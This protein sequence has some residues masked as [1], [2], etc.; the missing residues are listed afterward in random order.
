MSFYS[1][2]NNK[3]FFFLS[4]INITKT[5]DK[6]LKP[7]MLVGNRLI[8]VYGT[9][10][11][12][13]EFRKH[14]F[15][16]VKLCEMERTGGK[17]FSF[18]LA[19][20]PMEVLVY[21]FSFVT[22]ARDKVKLRYVSQRLRTAA[23]APSLWRDFTWSHYDSRE[24]ISIKNVLK[25]CGRYVQR[26][27]FPH[28]V[29]PVVYFQCCCNVK[30]LSL[31]CAKLTLEHLR[32]IMQ[33]MRKLQYLD[34]LW[35]SQN[36]IKWYFWVLNYPAYGQTIKELTIRERLD[37]SSGFYYDEVFL[38]L[39]KQWTKLKLIP[40]TLNICVK[41]INKSSILSALCQWTLSGVG[42]NFLTAHDNGN[43]NVYNKFNA[44]ISIPAFSSFQLKF[45]GT[46]ILFPFVTA[47][48]HGLGLPD[49]IM[50]NSQ[51]T[52]NGGVLHQGVMAMCYRSI[53][54]SKP[55]NPA[56]I[57]FITHFDVSEYGLLDSSHLEQLAF[58]CPKLQ[59]LNLFGNNNCLK[60]LQGLRVIASC[61][62]KL[63]G[64]NIS[65]I[66]VD[67]VESCVQLWKILTDL[68]LTYLAA[69]MCCLLC[70][71]DQQIKQ[72][73]FHLQQK[74][75]KLKALESSCEISCTKCTDNK[76]PLLLTNFPLLIHC[77][78][79]DINIV[80]NERLKYLLYSGDNIS[81][82][83][84]LANC[85]LEE[86]CIKSDQLT[87]SESLM[88][89]LSAHGR[90]VH[91]VLSVNFVSQDGIAALIENSPNLITCHAYIRNVALWRILF[92]ARDFI[93]RL[94]EQYSHRKLFLCGSCHVVKKKLS[95][96][97]FS[98][99]A[100]QFNMAIST[101]WHSYVV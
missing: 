25:L 46:E 17:D 3:A 11:N 32:T 47:S 100:E 44:V 28:L 34:I 52:A 95:E 93:S 18:N 98:V 55:Q 64:L 89:A 74:C 39:I 86:L 56:D 29:I 57:T 9:E 23:E 96:Y 4:P 53:Q 12:H 31:P 62:Q 5:R 87:L 51:T 71:E 68:Q 90:L 15:W 79:K 40:K 80:I 65:R 45:V 85:N 91:V 82:S 58:A 61:C 99:L 10:K 66:S 77:V 27:S 33:S 35:W 30:R 20:L 63:E 13:T 67:K 16:R 41:E 69:E 36:D 7:Q 24:T 92:N 6:T 101:V 21:L 94:K 84:P 14:Y 42:A 38:L 97:E 70:F 50:L 48:D 83:W 22:S 1:N 19:L 73:V 43:L 8:V 81:C 78:T 60:S 72:I 49:H 2:P 26:L 54:S 76:Q 59:Q 88:N 75:L 37:D